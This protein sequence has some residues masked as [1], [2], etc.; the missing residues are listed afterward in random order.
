MSHHTEE[1]GIVPDDRLLVRPYV[2]PPAH[3]APFTTPAWPLGPSAA[4]VRAPA[5]AGAPVAQASP[6]EGRRGSRRPLMV[7]ALLALAA[8]GTLVV[9]LRSPEPEPA[10][11][12]PPPELSVPV[13]P[14]RSPGTDDT[15]APH[16]SA[17]TAPSGSASGTPAPAPATTPAGSP[18][19]TPPAPP[20]TPTAPPTAP[21]PAVKPTPAT[22]GTLRPGDRGAEVRNL[23]ERLHGQ[24]FTYV[25]TTGVYDART[26]RGVAQLQ[27]DRS[28]KGDPYG[29]Y[30]PA[31]RA[32]FG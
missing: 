4:P 3:P 19:P 31:T 21:L 26:E 29:V 6:V 27:R 13:L 17:G 23:Q 2:T 30:G 9:L 22:Q 1:S 24:G 16:T 20:P 14:A 25:S 7:L 8:A 11:A 32:A 5:P 10:R 15:P 28:I 18:T 12:V